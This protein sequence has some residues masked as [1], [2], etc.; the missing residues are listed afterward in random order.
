ME[1]DT[2]L[3]H[4]NVLYFAGTQASIGL[5]LS[6]L[7]PVGI[8]CLPVVLPFELAG[9]VLF[10]PLDVAR[11][12]QYVCHPPLNELIRGNDLQALSQRLAQGD[13][14]NQIDFRFFGR[15]RWPSLPLMEAFH[16]GNLDAFQM[17]LDH[18]AEVPLDL[19]SRNSF[20]RITSMDSN[21]GIDFLKASLRKGVSQER[22]NS[23]A[24]GSV[25][26]DVVA[27]YARMPIDEDACC[28]KLFAMLALLLENGFPPN[29]K[30]DES[31]TKGQRFSALDHLLQAPPSEN[32]EKLV[33]LMRKYGAKTF[34]EL[35]ALNPHETLPPEINPEAIPA[36]FKPIIEILTDA[37][38][39]DWRSKRY[40]FAASYPGVNGPVVVVDLV[41]DLGPHSPCRQFIQIH[42]RETPTRWKQEGE[43]FEIPVYF[44][45][46]LTPPGVRIPSRLTEDLPPKD[47]LLE[48]WHTLPTCE[49]YIERPP[50]IMFS[51]RILEAER[52]IEKILGLAGISY[53]IHGKDDR[54]YFEHDPLNRMRH[55][56]F[57]NG[58]YYSG[59]IKYFREEY[60][61][62]KKAYAVAKEAGLQGFWLERVYGWR[63]FFYSSR[64]DLRYLDINCNHR[65]PYPDEIIAVMR[66]SSIESVAKSQN[67]LITKPCVHDYAKEHKGEYYWNCQVHDIPQKGSI[68]LYYGDE[69]NQEKIDDVVKMARKLMKW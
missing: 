69:V 17:L 30:L 32:R 2:P 28:N 51:H 4:P 11:H 62:E 13:D 39:S 52:D 31:W 59:S 10:L 54:Y 67:A 3:R 55:S 20:F 34:T 7:G 45:L 48:E 65:V 25:I 21:N 16:Q 5:S 63:G 41:R 56:F 60:N 35:N 15:D 1:N 66:I 50:F 46:V 64:R 37:H 24:A 29:G 12:I 22:I 58:E 36:C 47:I 40:R 49:L 33:E 42:R 53:D 8:A 18:N 19:F 68:T 57:K 14:P 38:H 6:T 43:P 27:E 9:D 61:W 44:R 23:V 26:Y